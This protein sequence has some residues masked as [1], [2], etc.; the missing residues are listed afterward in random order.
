MK[1]NLTKAESLHFLSKYQ[2]FLNIKIPDFFFISKND[3]RNRENQILK[4]IEK[5]FY[6]KKIIIRSS[7]LQEDKELI[8]MIKKFLIYLRN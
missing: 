3:F 4:K 2:K 5:K 6:R 8:M 1:R 7:S